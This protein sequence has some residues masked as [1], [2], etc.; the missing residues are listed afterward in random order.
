MLSTLTHVHLLATEDI[1]FLP[2]LAQSAQFTPYSTLQQP[3]P[4]WMD[5]TGLS[6]APAPIPSNYYMDPYEP[7]YTPN[8]YGAYFPPVLPATQ[9]PQPTPPASSCGDPSFRK[10]KYQLYP[11]PPPIIPPC[12]TEAMKQ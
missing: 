1:E 4:A 9:Y 3:F 12:E 10:S 11:Q 2:S 7:Q 6:Y 8:P 5:F